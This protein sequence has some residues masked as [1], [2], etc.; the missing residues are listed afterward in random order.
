MRSELKFILISIIGS[1]SNG[2]G[3]VYHYRDSSNVE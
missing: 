3:K 2:V 1:L